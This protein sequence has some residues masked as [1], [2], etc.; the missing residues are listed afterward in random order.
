MTKYYDTKSI[1]KKDATYN[2]IFGERSNGKT[3]ALLKKG[4]YNFVKT[5]KQMAYVRRW[6]E[7]ITGRRASRLFEGI[8][9]NNE[10]EKAT[11]GEF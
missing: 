7:D 5:R 6:K 3:Y 4:L 11:K 9:S 2:V 1:D 10:V 8:N